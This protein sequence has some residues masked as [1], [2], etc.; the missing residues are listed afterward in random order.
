MKKKF[1]CR[2][3][4]IKPHFHNNN[5]NDV[6]DGIYMPK[7]AEISVEDQSYQRK[8]IKQQTNID[9]SLTA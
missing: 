5:I 3:N 4:L 1:N 9:D 7:N 6:K 2:D 8:L